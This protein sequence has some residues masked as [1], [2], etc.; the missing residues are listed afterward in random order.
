MMFLFLLSG[1]FNNGGYKNN[2]RKRKKKANS[3]I[4]IYFQIGEY[5]FNLLEIQNFKC[6]FNLSN[7]LI[8]SWFKETATAW[9]FIFILYFV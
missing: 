8:L 3:I 7:N 1:E 9:C 2:E 4:I 5:I 6:S